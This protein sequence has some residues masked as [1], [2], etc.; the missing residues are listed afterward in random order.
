[1][2][3]EYLAAS[4]QNIEQ[5]LDE[6][7]TS[8]NQEFKPLYESMNYSLMQG[9]KR[10]RPILS[11]AV[12]EML[13]KDPAD[14]KEFL[15]AMECIHTYSLVHDDL[16]A[17]DNDDYRRGNLTN[18]KVYGEGLA[19]LAGDGLLTY[20]FQLMTANNKA[21]AQDKLDAIQC[22]AIA[23][24]PEGMVG[25]QAFDMLSEDKHIPLEE[26]KVLHRGKTGAL[27]NASVELGLILGN[28]DTA[29]RTA[30]MEYANCLGLL[31]QITDDILDVT[32]T[33]E[34]LGK[35]P[36]SD[37]RQ[38]K[39][40]YVS[41]LGLEGAKEQASSVGKQAHEALNSV[42]YDTSILAALIDYL[43]KRTN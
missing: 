31:F 18:H 38:H 30:L 3:K 1:M 43:L 40:T 11:K 26:L 10:I 29:T 23:A 12:L 27:F 42:S 21:S 19:I 16:P 39:S 33:I 28:A 14:Y 24:G 8:P 22:V 2:F 17:M 37:I 9:G 20:A 13:H 25:G 35:T 15:C 32:G 6:V 5:W 4:K 34:E 41:I 7:L 36:G